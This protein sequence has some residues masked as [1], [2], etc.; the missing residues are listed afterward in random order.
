MAANAIKVGF[1]I[2][3]GEA[4]TGWQTTPIKLI[5]KADL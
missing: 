5:T 2:L 1:R 3:N 4:L